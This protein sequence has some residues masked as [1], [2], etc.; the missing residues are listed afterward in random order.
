[1]STST[2]LKSTWPQAP[3]PRLSSPPA[4]APLGRASPR[5]PAP[6]SFPAARCCTRRAITIPTTADGHRAQTVRPVARMIVRG[7]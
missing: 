4:L 5:T 2:T 6:R 1:M 7:G 3:R